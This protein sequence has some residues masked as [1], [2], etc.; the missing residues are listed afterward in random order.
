[1]RVWLDVGCGG[2]VCLV[3]VKGCS[4]TSKL[5]GFVF[6]SVAHY[7]EFCFCRCWFQFGALAKSFAGLCRQR[8]S[9]IS[10]MR[11]LNASF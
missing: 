3:V 11:A 6:T 9:V 7:V 5:C 8:V 10:V 2:N 4:L 1:M